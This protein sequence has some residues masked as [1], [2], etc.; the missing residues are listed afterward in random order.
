MV[1][2]VRVAA[3]V[4][5][6]PPPSS[7]HLLERQALR[8]PFWRYAA[9]WR[10]GAFSFLLDSARD[11]TR[12]GRYSFV[13]GEPFLIYQA[14]AQAGQPAAA[15]ARVRVTRLRG[16]EGQP[17]RQP[18]VTEYTAEVFADLQRLLH[19]HAGRCPPVAAG[20]PLLA[21]A[22]GYFG[23]EAGRLIEDLPARAVDDLG[24]PTVYFGFYDALL[25]HDHAT[26][27]SY[28]SIRGR[29]DSESQARYNAARLRDQLR[30]RIVTF[31][32][33]PPPEWTGPPAG[34][35]VPPVEV[36]P[37]FDESAYGQVVQAARQ[38][39][40]AGDAFEVCTTYRLESPFAGD[41]WELYQELRRL[42]PAPFA[43][44]LHF[45]EVQVVCSSPERFLRL[46]ADRIAESRPIKGTRPRGRTAEEDERLARELAESV[47]D[48][49]ENLMIVDLVRNDFGR[50]CKPRSIHVPELLAVERYAT[51]FQLVSTIRGELAEG[52]SGLDLVRACFPPGS[53]TGAP[54][55]EA[56]KI[57]D[58]LEPTVRGIYSGAAGYLDYGGPL[59]LN[60]VIR[61]IL[62]KDGR[63]LYNVGGAVVADSDP[64]EEHQETLAKAKALLAAVANVRACCSHEDR[65]ARQL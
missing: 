18:A 64:H 36:Q 12:L 40:L 50:V 21:G 53:M 65:S 16:P 19:H 35:P 58:R 22:V 28:L 9:L 11:P 10:G 55:I 41:P 7:W 15:G 56:M 42:N 24:L 47:K 33:A 25:A 37:Q 54:K 45:P 57:I 38:H 4:V 63:A 44:Y 8:L 20:C 23:Y 17:L 27:Q 5:L 39:I 32:S 51:V 14:W 13:G 62:V 29:G 59:D 61:T 49:A 60:V 34:R 31:E 48:R 1:Y 46:G 52:Q 3:P 26:G 6:A 2:M 30:G 43:C